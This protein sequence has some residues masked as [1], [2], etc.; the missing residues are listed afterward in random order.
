MA[1]GRRNDDSKVACAGHNQD[2]RR[3]GIRAAQSRPR[4]LLSLCR[5]LIRPISLIETLNG[6]TERGLFGLR[7]ARSLSRIEG[8]GLPVLS[9]V[10]GA[11]LLLPWLSTMRG[12]PISRRLSRT[13][14]PSPSPDPSPTAVA[15]IASSWRKRLR[16]LGSA[17]AKTGVLPLK[18]G[19]VIV[20]DGKELVAA[21][22]GE[23]SEGEHAEF[24]ALERNWRMSKLPARRS[25]RRW[26]HVPPATIP[27][28]RA[29]SD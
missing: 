14:K 27:R 11:S 25:T 9:I 5:R 22:R 4:C 17:K 8:D 20:K 3:K 10:G 18:V 23:Q 21:Y 29:Q 24:T 13:E 19:A 12:I 28:C 6:P 7:F 1:Q 15:R 16:R 2:N 26:S